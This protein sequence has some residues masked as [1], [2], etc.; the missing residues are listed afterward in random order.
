MRRQNHSN[1]EAFPQRNDTGGCPAFSKGIQRKQNDS[2]LKGEP[3][4]STRTMTEASI[5][6]K[7]LSIR[8]EVVI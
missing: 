2:R 6:G 3:H 5:D 7:H 1:N 8:Q 4:G